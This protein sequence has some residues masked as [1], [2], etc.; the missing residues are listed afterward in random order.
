MDFKA[1]QKKYQQLLIENN[2]LKEEIKSLKAHPGL[3]AGQE[4]SQDSGNAVSGYFPAPE[5]ELF[6]QKAETE[7][8]ASYG[9]INKRSDPGEKVRLF[10]SLF[11]GRD[12][13]Y[14]KRWENKAK[15]T[16]GYS[17]ACGN[18]WEPG[19]PWP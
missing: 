16:A 4:E 17:P 19:R 11:R 18:E 9:T 8:P 6:G 15:R 14:A 2:S 12:D 3:T 7:P 5:P 1:L 10:M 13:V